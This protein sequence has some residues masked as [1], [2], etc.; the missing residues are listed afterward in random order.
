MVWYDTIF[1]RQNNMTHSKF[2]YQ[3]ELEA[4]PYCPENLKTIHGEDGGYSSDFPSDTWCTEMVFEM[5]K[6]AIVHMRMTQM[7]YMAAHKVPDENPLPEH[8]A[9]LNY[10]EKKIDWYERI[11][12]SMKCV[13]EEKVEA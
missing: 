7:K 8:K 6:D 5:I 10:C 12:K 11:E 9:F 4:V 2:T 3:F 13:K 1:T